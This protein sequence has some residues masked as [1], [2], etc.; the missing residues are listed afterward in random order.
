MFCRRTLCTTSYTGISLFTTGHQKLNINNSKKNKQ[1]ARRMSEIVS[2]AKDVSVKHN[3]NEVTKRRKFS[4]ETDV[5]RITCDSKKYTTDE[6]AVT[7]KRR[8]MVLKR[9]SNL[10]DEGRNN[11]FHALSYV[12]HGCDEQS[13]KFVIG[14]GC[15]HDYYHYK[16][17]LKDFE[18]RIRDNIDEPTEIIL[19]ARG[20]YDRF[21]YKAVMEAVKQEEFIW[22]DF[23][24][25]EDKGLESREKMEAIGRA[26]SLAETTFVPLDTNDMVILNKV[27][28]TMND[29]D[30]VYGEIFRWIN[31]NEDSI[32]NKES[33]KVYKMLESKL[34]PI[35]PIIDDMKATFDA[36]SMFSYWSRAWTFQEQHLSQEIIYGYVDDNCKFVERI[37]SAKILSF[38]LRHLNN[39]RTSQD[40]LA[41]VGLDEVGQGNNID[42]VNDYL[43]YIKRLLTGRECSKL[44]IELETGIMS[45]DQVLIN[46][47][48]DSIKCANNRREFCHVMMIALHSY[49]TTETEMWQE[50][51]R[52][53]VE[54]GFIP[55]IKNFSCGIKKY[56]WCPHQTITSKKREL[57]PEEYKKY[58]KN[59]YVSTDLLQFRYIGNDHNNVVYINHNGDLVIRAKARTI[60]VE[61]G[62][63]EVNSYIETTIM[64]ED[65]LVRSTDKAEY[66]VL[67]SDIIFSN[68][69]KGNPYEVQP[70]VSKLKGVMLI[71]NNEDPY[72][73]KRV[74]IFKRML[75]ILNSD[76]TSHIGTITLTKESR[77]RWEKYLSE[78][79]T[80]KEYF[81][82]GSA[83]TWIK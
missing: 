36:K 73:D 59:N 62:T 80:K 70:V 30:E 23:L 16:R 17:D 33:D 77:D 60:I 24:S 27:L 9:Y 54:C 56:G 28:Q 82:L 74:I 19:E 3:S 50:I 45:M 58:Y 76:E 52:K 37:S 34:K 31:D 71:D 5:R 10:Y 75:L 81:V 49:G 53:A 14:E 57:E 64:G 1:Q 41:P 78:H 39:M 68:K 7:T 51:L 47:L 21:K 69:Q 29:C 63:A 42:M 22:T 25:M 38:A 83:G 6:T 35:L 55:V 48:C 44:S 8:N 46:T 15:H 65:K 61:Q 79:N 18:E 40:M 13:K 32:V 12:S 66:N 43:R 67:I 11:L 2:E 4:I 20:S 72:G 26:Y